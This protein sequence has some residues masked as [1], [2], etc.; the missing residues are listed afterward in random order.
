MTTNLLRGEPQAEPRM[1]SRRWKAVAVAAMLLVL[2]ILGGGSANA[3]GFTCTTTLEKH[4]SFNYCVG[5]IVNLRAAKYPAGTRVVLKG[6]FVFSATN[7]VRNVG[8]LIPCPPGKFCG[9][10][11]N[12]ATTNIDFSR[13]SSAPAIYYYTDIW[14]T[15]SGTT[16]KPV[17]YKLGAFGGDPAYW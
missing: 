12:W 7:K 11:L 5:S 16:L 10:T 9:A 13:L 17:G 4:G 2:P 6:A 8:Q 1:P 14:G 15:S 3:A